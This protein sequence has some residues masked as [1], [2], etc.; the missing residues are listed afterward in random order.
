MRKGIAGVSGYQ[1][2]G[3]VYQTEKQGYSTVK[4][5]LSCKNKRLR[6]TYH[7]IVDY[8]VFTSTIYS[9]TILIV[10]VSEASTVERGIMMQFAIYP[11]VIMIVNVTV[12]IVGM[13]GVVVGFDL[14]GTFSLCQPLLSARPWTLITYFF[15]Y[16]ALGYLI[17]DM[18]I[19]FLYGRA[20]CRIAGPKSFI[21]TYLSG[22]L[23]A[24]VVLLLFAPPLSITS[25][26]GGAIF[27]TAMA[28][29]IIEPKLKV[30]FT[31]LWIA[32]AAYFVLALFV[33]PNLIIP[34]LPPLIALP[35]AIGG[36]IIGLT[37]GLIL[38]YK[39]AQI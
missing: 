37:A 7:H 4:A 32:T 20:F 3:P 33:Y 29:T 16:D 8:P 6:I 19:L 14:F 21:I 1:T 22:G 5:I 30:W 15:T 24:G 12:W 28:L 38:R 34:R 39:Q 2:I 31:S 36:I 27:A 35:T 23:F 13:I 18:L 11:M 10:E 26:A 9:Y 17:P 25:G